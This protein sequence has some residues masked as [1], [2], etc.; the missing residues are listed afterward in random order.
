MPDL[1]VF[2]PSRTRPHNIARLMDA[3]NQTCRA[4]TTLIVGLDWDDPTLPQYPGFPQLSDEFARAT[5]TQFLT[6]PDGP[7]PGTEYEVRA[8]FRQVVAWMNALCMPRLADYKCVGHIGDDNVPRTDGWDVQI[9]E[10]LERTPFAYANDLYGRPGPPNPGAL[11][12]HVFMRSE[13]TRALGFLGQPIFRHMYVDVAWMQ[14]G[15]ATGIT[16]LED[17]IIEHM[18]YTNGKAAPDASYAASTGLIP[19]DL[20]VYQRYCADPRGLAADVEVIRKAVGMESTGLDP[21]IVAERNARYNV[22][23]TPAP[24]GWKPGDPLR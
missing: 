2:V 6:S 15:E 19:A 20:Q 3:M 14:W 13:V 9:L 11:C 16:Y 23:D 7:R 24:E 1:G 8:G 18:H 5:P 17:C 4:Q 21:A 10:A 12:C 22:P